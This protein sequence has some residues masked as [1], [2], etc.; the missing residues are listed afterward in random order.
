M[1]SNGCRKLQAEETARKDG[2]LRRSGTNREG[3]QRCRRRG[4]QT[5]GH[6]GL[7]RPSTF[8]SNGLKPCLLS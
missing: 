7:W 1:T 8:V 2:K 6:T 3:R 4:E 5:A